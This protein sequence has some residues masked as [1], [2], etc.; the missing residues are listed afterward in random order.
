MD[1]K[2]ATDPSR[3]NA[4]DHITSPW[5]TLLCRCLIK[6]PLTQFEDILSF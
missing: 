3:Y 4:T 6:F 2:A 1:V 5:G